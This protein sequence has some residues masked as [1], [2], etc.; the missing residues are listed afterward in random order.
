MT[1]P[2][3]LGMYVRPSGA[4]VRIGTTNGTTKE[5]TMLMR[6]DPYRE[7]DILTQA[8]AAGPGASQG[9]VMAMDAYR[10]GGRHVGTLTNRRRGV[11]REL[12]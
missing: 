11:D 3:D 1:P 2:R 8:L 12:A 6:F 5:Q 4:S 7:L 9:T 10:D